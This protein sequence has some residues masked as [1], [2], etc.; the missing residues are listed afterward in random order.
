MEPKQYL[1][2]TTRAG[3]LGSPVA[4]SDSGGRIGSDVKKIANNNDV[5]VLNQKLVGLKQKNLDLTKL[6]TK[7]EREA[8]QLQ[9]NET[10]ESNKRQ[11]L[12]GLIESQRTV[13]GLEGKFADFGVQYD[14]QSAQSQADQALRNISSQFL[15]ADLDLVVQVQNAEDAIAT[16]K[17][18]QSILR[19]NIAKFEAVGTP[20]AIAAANVAS[21][22]SAELT[23]SLPELEANLEQMLAIQESSDELEQKYTD[24]LTRQNELKISQENLNKR[25]LLLSQKATVAEARGTLEAQREVKLHQE[26]LRLALKILELRQQYAPGEYLDSLITG[27]RTQ[28]QVNTENINYDSQLQEF[29]LEKKRQYYK[30]GIGDK[31]G[32]LLSRFGINFGSE[33]ILKENAIA[34]ENLRFERELVQLRK[35]YQ[36]RPDELEKLSRAATELNRV[37]LAEIENQFRT[38]GQSIEE[39]FGSSVSGFFDQFTT[40]FFDGQAERDRAFMEERLRYAEELNQLNDQYKDKPG[41][42]AHLK[43]RARELNEQKLD[44]IK[45]EFDIFG[46]AVDLAKQALLE[47]VKQL[48][49]MAAK[50]AAAKFIGSILGGALGGIGGGGVSQ[51]GNDFGSINSLS[52]FVA[53]EGQTVGQGQSP[54]SS[55]STTGDA[56]ASRDIKD[57]KVSDRTTRYLRRTFPGIASAYLA[58]GKDAQLGVFHKNE[59][60]ISDKTGEAPAYRGLKRIFGANPAQRIIEN[61]NYGGMVGFDAGTNILSGFSSPIRQFDLSQLNYSNSSRPSMPNK[62]INLTQTIVT[63]DADSFRTNSDQR[64]QD[65]MESLS[66]RI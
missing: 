40:N 56:T 53:D 59:E 60:L 61:F 47:F 31:K 33:R 55:S 54:S 50:A 8:L 49:R 21:A 7:Q 23:A 41:E 9:V 11:I 44:K 18:A 13:T 28:S 19:D 45:Q 20:E 65:L 63:P 35:E 66:R 42:L 38:L 5:V 4:S 48:A 39:S 3:E 24:Y 15:D 36:D 10:I 64:N 26:D 37:S 1:K 27:E 43:N 52:A 32:S 2:R 46:R 57:R 62:T 29:D 30:S 25:N 17:K 12:Q 6:T 16:I 34:Q 14:F 22:S 58:E 51:V